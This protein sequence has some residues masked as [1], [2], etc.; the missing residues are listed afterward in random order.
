MK[1]TKD[2]KDAIHYADILKQIIDDFFLYNYFD[3]YDFM[4]AYYCLTELCGDS[5]E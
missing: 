2:I 1:C 4:D 5:C 3:E